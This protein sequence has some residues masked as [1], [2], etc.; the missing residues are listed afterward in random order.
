[1]GTRNQNTPSYRREAQAIAAV[2]CDECGAP[3]GAPCRLSPATR[4]KSPGRLIVHGQRRRS[5]QVW[6]A[7]ARD[8]DTRTA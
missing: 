2:A 3:K 8:G 6:R 5:W 1:M 4:A 7:T